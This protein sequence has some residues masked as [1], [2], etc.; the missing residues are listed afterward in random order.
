[1]AYRRSSSRGISRRRPAYTARRAPARRPGARRAASRAAPRGGVLRIV[2]EQAAPT[3]ARQ[4]INQMVAP[5][6][7]KA[8]L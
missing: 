8:R 4:P 1:M 5:P 2:V 3:I 6:A 7:R